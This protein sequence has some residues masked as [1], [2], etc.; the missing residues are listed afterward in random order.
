MSAHSV[1]RTLL[2]SSCIAAPLFGLVAAVA[3]PALKSSRGAEITAISAL[4]G[5]FYV[6]AIFVLLSGYL[7]VPAV[8]GLLSLVRAER[9][10]WALTAGVIAQAGLLVAIGDAAVELMYWQMGR[11]SADH[12]QMT[13]LANRYENAPGSSLVYSIGGLA[14]LIGVVLLAIVLW[15]TRAIPRLAAVA[16]VLGTIANGLGFAAASRPILVGSYVL[17]GACLVPAALTIYSRNEE[18]PV[19]SADSRASLPTR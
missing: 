12:Q 11:P 18:F 10:G 16:L 3:T 1:K 19:V 17:L 4:P 2:A 6:Y 13:A 5:R 8:F 9:P 14:T 15:R 7:L